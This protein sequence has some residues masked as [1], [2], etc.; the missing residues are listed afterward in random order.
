MFGAAAAA[1]GRSRCIGAARAVSLPR[2]SSGCSAANIGGSDGG[3]RRSN[4]S[5]SSSSAALPPRA[6]RVLSGIQPTGDLHLGN[7]LGALRQWVDV[8]NDP[9]YD[10]FFCVVDL[11]AV[12]A[13]H[14]PRELGEATR[15]AAALFMACGVDPARS[16]IFA[17]SHVSAHAELAWLLN[18]ITPMS[19][20]ERM[21]QYKDKVAKQQQQ[22]Q[23]LRQAAAGSSEGGDNSSG[24]GGGG[25]GGSSTAGLGLFSYP[26]LMAADILLYQA[27]LV[28]VGEDQRQHLELTRELAR[29]FH[30]LY[31][32]KRSLPAGGRRCFREPQALIVPDGA[33]LMSLQDGTSKMSKSDPADGSRI[34]MTDPPELIASKIRKCRTDG[35]RGGLRFGDPA[36]PECTNLLNMYQAATG[37]SRAAVEEEVEHMEWSAFKPRLADALVAQ[38]API[39]ARYADVLGD[40]AGLQAVLDEGAARADEAAQQT[41][42]RAKH[43]MGFVPSPPRT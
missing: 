10:T 13:A 31:C 4:S 30:D 32:R 35:V 9:A 22:Q 5:S 6:A 11:H 19:W 16:T 38:L 36:R 2:V 17:Q 3:G 28:P 42:Q 25:G 27:E 14:D 23:Q 29:R 18:C 1:I 26:V 41:L 37:Q 40:R 20:L 8:A 12:T 15:K 7:Y 34:N 33:R 43:A 21:T 39:Q 24:G